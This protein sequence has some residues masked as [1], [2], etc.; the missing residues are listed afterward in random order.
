MGKTTDNIKKHKKD[1]DTGHRGLESF[2]L[3]MS[4]Q[5]FLCLCVHIDLY[6]FFVA[7]ALNNM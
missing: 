6:F 5:T 7:L 3:R 1:L 2:V 4:I